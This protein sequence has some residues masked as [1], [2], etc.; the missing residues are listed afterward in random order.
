LC[1]TDRILLREKQIEYL[2][3][4]IASAVSFQ[5]GRACIPTTFVP[6]LH[7]QGKYRG[8]EMQ[9]QSCKFYV[10]RNA[11]LFL[12]T[13]A[14]LAGNAASGSEHHALNGT[15][16]LIPA[17]SELAGEPV[18]PTGTITI[19]DRQH[20]ISITRNFNYEGLN[21]TVSFS[22]STDG[23]ENSSI[24]QGKSFKSKAKWEGNELKVLSTQD[25]G[26]STER[27]NQSGDG[28]MMLV[29]ERPGHRTITLFFE[30]Q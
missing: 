9:S 10:R 11:V 18:I 15:W 6:D 28:T 29:V 21:Q 23:R 3:S 1:P 27:F 24:H 25:D 7:L 26:T 13:M 4:A 5:I 30:R 22:F 19:D 2:P 8:E 20:N 17:R 14:V 12:T 16:R